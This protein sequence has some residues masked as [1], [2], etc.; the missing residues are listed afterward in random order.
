MNLGQE[1]KK[2]N[3]QALIIMVGYVLPFKWSHFIFSINWELEDIV[4]FM[5]VKGKFSMSGPGRH[6]DGG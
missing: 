3:Q 6:I 5:Y 1:K 4:Q 2:K